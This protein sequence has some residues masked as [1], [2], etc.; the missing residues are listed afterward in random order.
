ML[1]STVSKI[2]ISQFE[3]F[4]LK[5]FSLLF[6]EQDVNTA[7]EE[8]RA[9]EQEYNKE[10]DRFEKTLESSMSDVFKTQQDT[11]LYFCQRLENAE[12]LAESFKKKFEDCKQELSDERMRSTLRNVELERQLE[13]NLNEVQRLQTKIFA[14]RR[15]VE[16]QVEPQRCEKGVLCYVRTVNKCTEVPKGD[17]YDERDEQLKVLQGELH[18]T[19]RQVEVLQD[20]LLIQNIL[21]QQLSDVETRKQEL[22]A[23]CLD[24]QK[25]FEI[26]EAER[27]FE[28]DDFDLK[29]KNVLEEKEQMARA[30]QDRYHRL[31]A[32]FDN[33]RQEMDDVIKRYESK[34]AEM[35]TKLESLEKESED[36]KRLEDDVRVLKDDLD[37]LESNYEREKS[38]L[39]LKEDELTTLRDKL[40]SS[41]DLLSNKHEEIIRI[42]SSS[43]EIDTSFVDI[44]G[45]EKQIREMT[46]ECGVIKETDILGSSSDVESISTLEPDEYIPILTFSKKQPPTKDDEESSATKSPDM[47]SAKDDSLSAADVDVGQVKK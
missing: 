30:E 19:R 42:P 36:R 41:L 28:R 45:L 32:E 8:L 47:L 39:Q 10:R 24:L 4:V 37:Q 13:S 1:G 12:K 5:I 22:N 23:K 46:A 26:L 17:L 27:K 15:H 43:S 31:E 14:N 25:K 38:E 7:R 21:Q 2:K 29:Y 35:K 9:I 11:S 3:L 34:K 20:K 6:L 44:S 33:V 18:A 40:K 16:I